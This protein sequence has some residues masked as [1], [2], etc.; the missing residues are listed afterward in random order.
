M[1]CSRFATPTGDIAE[2]DR[3]QADTSRRIRKYILSDTSD[4]NYINIQEQTIAFITGT[5]NSSASPGNYEQATNRYG[6][7]LYWQR[8][9]DS[10]HRWTGI[11]WTRTGN[12]FTRQRL[13]PTGLCTSINTMS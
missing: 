3:G 4:D 6:Q 5:F 8:E 10:P 2:L 12:R 13:P 1:P 9:P 11:R 7:A